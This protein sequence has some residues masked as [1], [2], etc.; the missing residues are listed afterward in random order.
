MRI[1][2]EAGTL[3]DLFLEAAS[4]LFSLMYDKEEVEAKRSLAIQAYADSAEHLFVEFLN[5]LLSLMGLSEMFFCAL[6]IEVV[7]IS[8]GRCYLRGILSGEKA[9]PK[10]HKPKTEVKAATYSGLKFVETPG[11]YMAQCLLDL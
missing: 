4:G 11:H 7:N 8:P 9:D 5:E 3:N 6:T 2:V 10:K 1:Q